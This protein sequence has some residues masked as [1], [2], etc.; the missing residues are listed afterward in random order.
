M[1]QAEV[2]VKNEDIGYL[3]SGQ[4]AEVKVNTFPFAEYGVLHGTVEKI[5]G[6]AIEDERLGL[7]YK[8]IVSLNDNT[9][10]K[11][12][13]DYKIVPG[14][15]VVAKVKTGTRRVIDFFT[16]PLTRGIDNSLRER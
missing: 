12:G 2:Y 15:A 6:D 1:L 4:E 16:E 7:V 14:M 8:L 5:S 10:H 9:L 11:D 13:E 3:K